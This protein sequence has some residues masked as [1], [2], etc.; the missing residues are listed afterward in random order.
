[1]VCRTLAIGYLQFAIHAVL[2]LLGELF[3]VIVVGH[4]RRQCVDFCLFS[5]LGGEFRVVSV[6]LLD[7]VHDFEFASNR[8]FAGRF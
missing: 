7:V 4:D 2:M 1:M 3:E 6:V 5:R 8:I